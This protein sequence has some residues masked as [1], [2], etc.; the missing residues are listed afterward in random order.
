M[1]ARHAGLVAFALS[2]G[3]ALA[4]QPAAA[5]YGAV[6]GEWRSY[7]GDNGS[8]KYSPLD[9]IDA[10]NFSDL[11]IAWRW[12]SVDG[13]VDLESL[14]RRADDRPISIRG[15]QATP[16]MI[17]GVLYLSTAL[18]QAAAVGRRH[19]RDHLGARSAS[20]RRRRPDARLPLARPRLLERRQ[21]RPHLLGHQRGVLIAVDARTGEPVR[22]FGDNGPGRPDGGRPAGGPGRDQLPGPQ[23]GR[24]SLATGHHPRRGRHADHHLGLRHP[25]GG[26][27]RLGQGGSTR[28]RATCGGCSAPSR[29]RTTSVPT[30]G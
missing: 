9:Q 1:S 6:D 19:R 2:A 10:G 17:D 30:R 26:A 24:G 11:R 7:A 5:Q 3:F 29:R 20:L 25:Q 4:G 21:R 14:P 8:T 16:L 28:A 18:Y 12:Q 22:D 27:A 13:N 23:P 15:L